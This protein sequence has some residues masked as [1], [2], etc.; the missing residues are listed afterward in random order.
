MSMVEVIDF[1]KRDI[2][3]N[4]CVKIDNGITL[5]KGR[6]GSGKTTLLDCISGLDK[7]YKGKIL[8]NDSSIYLNQ[9]LY[10]SGRLKVKDFIKFILNLSGVKDTEDYYITNANK[11]KNEFDFYGLLDK[12]M[13]YLSGGE[14]KLLF[15]F[16]ISIIDRDLYIFDEPY[17]G[18]DTKGKSIINSIFDELYNTGKSIILTSHEEQFIN[19]LQNVYVLDLD[20]AIK[21]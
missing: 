9:N 12:K 10:F 8:G 19:D 15:V 4:F 13:S 17:A 18:V 2:Y 6:N 21:L 7:D 1:C 3:N 20:N 5:I 11:H 16:V 14:V